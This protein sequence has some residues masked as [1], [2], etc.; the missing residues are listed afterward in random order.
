MH[1]AVGSL[2]Q[3]LNCES[4]LVRLPGCA[5]LSLGRLRCGVLWPV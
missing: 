2:M 5:I 3:A 1:N 4:G